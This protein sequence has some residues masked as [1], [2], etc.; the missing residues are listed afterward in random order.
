M[1][2]RKRGRDLFRDY[3]LR[4][5]DL[6]RSGL[7]ERGAAL[8]DLQIASIEMV[9]RMFVDQDVLLYPN[10]RRPQRHDPAIAFPNRADELRLA[11]V[12]LAGS[13]GKG[14]AVIHVVRGHIFEVD[15]RPSPKRLGERSSI[16]TTGITLHADPIIPD[17]GA[18][19]GRLLATLDGRTR[20]EYEAI[21]AENSGTSVLSGLDDLYSIHLDDGEYLMLA[22]LPD[23]RFVVAPTHPKG[24]GVRRFWPDGDPIMY[25]PNIRAALD[26]AEIDPT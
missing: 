22:Q 19:A 4:V 13:N 8:L 24:V 26:D 5:I 25:Y 6:V 21:V 14:K 3:E 11:T 7:D 10:R 9:Q 17:D 15:F 20:A 1:W 16:R 18:G 2:W 12:R 23:T